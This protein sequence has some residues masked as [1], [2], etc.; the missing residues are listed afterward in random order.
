MGMT[1]E[2]LSAYMKEY[3]KKHLSRIRRTRKEWWK[4]NSDRVNYE[5]RVRYY[6]DP[7]FRQWDI[8]RHLK[9]KPK[10]NPNEN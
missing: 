7:E 9:H 2:E 5:R 10:E 4:K 6:T 1:R 8:E 3:R